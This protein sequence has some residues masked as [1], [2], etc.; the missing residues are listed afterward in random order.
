MLIKEVT[1]ASGISG[2]RRKVKE[3][4]GRRKWNIGGGGVRGRK[5]MGE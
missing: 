5:N 2:W 4:G 1:E 3:R